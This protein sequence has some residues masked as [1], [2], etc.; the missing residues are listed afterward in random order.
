MTEAQN[1]STRAT[2]DPVLARFARA[3]AVASATASASAD[4]LLQMAPAMLTQTPIRW[5]R[6]WWAVAQFGAQMLVLMLSPSSYRRSQ[7]PALY[8]QLHA[9]SVPILPGFIAMS[10]LLSLVIIRIVVAT[11]QS[12]G[13]SQYALDV[14][15][16]TLV[17]ELLPLLVALYVALR[18]TMPAGEAVAELREQGQL[19]AL[20]H[21]GG[22]PARDVLLPRVLGGVFAVVLLAAL[23]AIMALVMTYV[24][25]YGFTNWGFASYTRDVGQVFNPAATVILCMKAF[26]FSLVVAILPLAPDPRHDGASLQRRDEINQLGRL[27]ALILL[28]EVLSLVG[29]YY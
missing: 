24:T 7:H 20:W 9:A 4:Q 5:L 23:S 6:G 18:F 8:Y 10:A 15:V 16:R 25:L 19:Q 27:F 11:A 12:Y 17:L 21:A 29:N 2:A 28:I 1:P 22:D 13:L 26:F 14:L 3:G